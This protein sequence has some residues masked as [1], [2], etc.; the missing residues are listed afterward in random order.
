LEYKSSWPDGCD[1]YLA[2]QVSQF[3]FEVLLIRTPRHTV[4]PWCGVPLKRVEA[5]RQQINGDVMQQRGKPCMLTSR[6]AARRTTANPFDA[7]LWLCVQAA[8]D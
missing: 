7:A 4:D 8:A 1:S 2:V 5:I 6:C 3:L